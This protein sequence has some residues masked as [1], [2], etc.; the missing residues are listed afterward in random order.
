[1]LLGTGVARAVRVH[2][3][4]EVQGCRARGQGVVAR[5]ELLLL[6]LVLGQGNLWAP[7]LRCAAA[8]VVVLDEEG[9][10]KGV[11]PCFP[12]RPLKRSSPFPLLGQS[13]W[14]PQISAWCQK[15]Y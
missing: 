2:S 3:A 6:P 8:V 4:W 7:Q 5:Y 14:L 12:R 9:R 13:R 1:M 15:G 10:G 11:A